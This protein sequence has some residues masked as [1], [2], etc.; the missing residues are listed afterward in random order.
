MSSN[1]FFLVYTTDYCPF[2]VRAKNLLKQLGHDFNEIDVTGKDDA[3]ANLVEIS[4]GRKTV[5]QIFEKSDAGSTEI[6]G[7]KYAHI[8][9]FDDL[10]EYFKSA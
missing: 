10:S 1:R 8:G 2:C 7:E 4:G 6:D 5:P 9:G 3:R